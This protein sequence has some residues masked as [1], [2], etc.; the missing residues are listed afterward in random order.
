ML[1]EA[2]DKKFLG[3]DALFVALETK[4]ASKKRKKATVPS[5]SNESE[6]FKYIEKVGYKEHIIYH[7][8][9]SPI[10]VPYQKEVHDK[11]WGKMGLKQKATKGGY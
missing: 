2:R 4:Q 9:I 10:C 5:F 6:Q 8:I 3:E 1:E 7:N 11:Y